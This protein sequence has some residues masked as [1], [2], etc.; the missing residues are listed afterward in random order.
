MC[1]VHA[2]DEF[3]LTRP[4]SVEEEVEARDALLVQVVYRLCWLF[5]HEVWQEENIMV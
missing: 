5:P 4:I 2:Y 3:L 1:Q